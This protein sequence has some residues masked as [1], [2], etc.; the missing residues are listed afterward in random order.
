MF[1]PINDRLRVGGRMNSAIV[2]SI[3]GPDRPGIVG[4]LSQQIAN[5]GGNWDES[6]MLSRGS[7]FAGIVYF[8]IPSDAVDQCSSSFDALRQQGFQISVGRVE[9]IEEKTTTTIML[10]LV[11]QD[12]PGIVKEIS[13]TLNTHNVNVEELST[14]V[15][16]ASMAGGD[17]FKMQAVL[18]IPESLDIGVL[19]QSLEGLA[20]ELMVD[21]NLG[22]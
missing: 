7:T 11:G 1:L 8:N 20:N 5:S 18:H 9:G 22:S 21:I 19:Q 2:L 3:I 17:L 16:Q 4:E 15:S 12:R 13:E 6:S 10:D 14:E